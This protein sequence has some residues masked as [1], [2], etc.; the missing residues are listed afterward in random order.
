MKK[1]GKSGFQLMLER[2]HAEAPTKMKFNAFLKT[3]RVQLL[4]KANHLFA[5]MCNGRDPGST[6]LHKFIKENR[7]AIDT[8]RVVVTKQKEAFLA[9]KLQDPQRA[10]I[11]SAD[12]ICTEM[13]TLNKGTVIGNIIAENRGD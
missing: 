7:L 8:F 1:R 11:V 9:Y 5:E 2:M 10:F 4:I 12:G 13:D 6:S 3:E